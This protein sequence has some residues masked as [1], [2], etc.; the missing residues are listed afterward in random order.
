MLF[1]LFFPRCPKVLSCHMSAIILANSHKC[2]PSCIW[3]FHTICVASDIWEHNGGHTATY[4]FR[5]SGNILADTVTPIIDS[6]KSDFHW[7][8]SLYPIRLYQ[9]G[10]CEVFMWT[11]GMPSLGIPCLLSLVPNVMWGGSPNPINPDFVAFV[12]LVCVENTLNFFFNLTT[13]ANRAGPILQYISTWWQPYVPVDLL[14]C[15]SCFFPNR[16]DLFNRLGFIKLFNLGWMSSLCL[17][18]YRHHM[19]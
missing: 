5:T 19:P 13:N 15:F 10:L 4:Y 6:Q 16:T 7:I 18:L 11:M 17:C 8:L 12:L 3:Q 2:P 14:H 9:A 1:F